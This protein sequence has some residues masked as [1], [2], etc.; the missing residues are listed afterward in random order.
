L[1]VYRFWRYTYEVWTVTHFLLDTA[2]IGHVKAEIRIIMGFSIIVW[3]VAIGFLLVYFALCAEVSET[4]D[5]MNR[6]RLVWLLFSIFFSP[7]LS[8]FMLHCLG[9]IEKG[10]RIIQYH[11]KDSKNDIIIKEADE[12]LAQRRNKV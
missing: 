12:R 9:P 3:V 4:A 2:F 8:A 11:K 6:N 10:E 7:I 1:R 5:R